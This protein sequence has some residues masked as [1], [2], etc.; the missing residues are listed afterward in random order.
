LAE[1]ELAKSQG[2]DARRKRAYAR[3]VSDS[4]TSLGIPSM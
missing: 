3:H 4:A 1:F 2:V